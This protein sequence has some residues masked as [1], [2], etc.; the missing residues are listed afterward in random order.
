M[1]LPY[2]LPSARRHPAATRLLLVP[3][4]HAHGSSVLE[5]LS[6]LRRALRALL[7]FAT[8]LCRVP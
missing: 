1:R 7:A 8:M 6:P 2:V 3:E 5:A 4:M